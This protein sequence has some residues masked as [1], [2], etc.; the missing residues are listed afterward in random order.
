MEKRATPHFVNCLLKLCQ[1]PLPILMGFSTRFGL[2]V[3][4]DCPTGKLMLPPLLWAWGKSPSE[5][6]LAGGERGLQG[7]GHTCSVA[8]LEL[9]AQSFH[10]CPEIPAMVV[11]D[12]EQGLKTGEGLW[13]PGTRLSVSQGKRSKRKEKVMPMEEREGVGKGT[14]EATT[15]ADEMTD[16]AVLQPGVSILKRV[17]SHLSPCDCPPG[18]EADRSP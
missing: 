10:C 11:G 1:W 14:E 9:K 12:S 16:P 18:V 13:W 4:W 2:Y 7:M 6:Q 5:A 3:V 15:V 8:E 17:G